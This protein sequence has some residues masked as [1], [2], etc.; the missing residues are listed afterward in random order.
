MDRK[1]ARDLD[2]YLTREPPDCL[3]GT[4]WH[5][6]KCQWTGTEDELVRVETDDSEEFWGEVVHR[7]SVEDHCPSCHSYN[8]RAV[9]PPDD[10]EEE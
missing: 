4:T 9:E 8:V 7:I 5:C 3:D 6:P 10:E 2:R 1:L